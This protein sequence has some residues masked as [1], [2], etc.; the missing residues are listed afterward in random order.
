MRIRVEI[1]RNIK[2]RC[3]FCNEFVASPMCTHGH[4]HACLHDFL[5]IMFH[6]NGA[7]K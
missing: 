5:G 4:G 3:N 6:Q 2:Y 7:K 1:C